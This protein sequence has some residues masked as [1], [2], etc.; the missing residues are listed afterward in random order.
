MRVAGVDGCKAG[1]IVLI[2]EPDGRIRSVI[3]ANATVIAMIDPRPEVVAIDIPIGLPDA[4]A[5]DCD[6]AARVRLGARGSSVFP[7][8][9]RPMLA[10][11]DWN[12]ACD[13][14][15]RLEGRRISRQAWAIASKIREVD[16]VLRSDT[17]L[18]SRLREF[19]P[20][21][22]FREWSGAPMPHAKK[23]GPGRIARQELV[24]RHFGA[25]AFAQTRDRHPRSAVADDDILDAF[26]GVWTAERVATGAADRLP[27]LPPVDSAGLPM[28]MVY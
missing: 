1:W 7:A 2:R 24:A 16:A 9:L 10:A 21:L 26:A 13:I 3:A 20:E 11:R 18:R 5:R 28:E 19:H 22:S 15:F 4:G 6:R 25:D 12:E 27:P 8:P 23:S 17:D 14:G